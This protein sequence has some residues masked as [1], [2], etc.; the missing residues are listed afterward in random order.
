VGSTACNLLTGRRKGQCHLLITASQH[1]HHLFKPRESNVCVESRDT[2][3]RFG[4]TL[5]CL[6]HRPVFSYKFRPT[7][8]ADRERDIDYDDQYCLVKRKSA[9]ENTSLS[10]P[11]DEFRI[12]SSGCL[13]SEGQMQER[14][15]FY[16]GSAIQWRA[17]TTTPQQVCG[18]SPV[19]WRRRP[20][21]QLRWRPRRCR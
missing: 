12:S 3:I 13:L 15:R 2:S 17:P 7:S 5:P 19:Y 9:Y 10:K 4:A 21:E 1:R 18:A 6:G 8:H 11:I 16:N 20:R 14:H